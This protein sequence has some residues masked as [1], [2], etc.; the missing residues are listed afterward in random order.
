MQEIVKKDIIAVL[1]DLAEILN[2][3][4]EKDIREIRE[5]SNHT[6]HNAS[7]FQ[8]EDSISIAVLIYSLSKIIERQQGAL[9][10][11]KILEMLQSCITSL[12]SNEENNFRKS[13]KRMFEFIKTMDNKLKMYINEVI[14][15]AQL[16]KGCK[17]CAHGISVARASEVLGVSQWE[18]LHY[19]GNTTI[20]D[21]FAEP[22][23]VLGR[24]KA[25]R[26]LFS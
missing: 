16:K 20:H 26:G 14:N 1:S 9:N 3:K 4:E 8:D 21:R 18:L 24:L 13:V 15:H 2:I 23:S 19:L 6:I 22:V 12:K 7:I 11:N 17:L 10:Y 5:L 25:A